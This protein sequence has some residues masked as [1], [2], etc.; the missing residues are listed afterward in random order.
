MPTNS[1]A[2]SIPSFAG[3][4]DE[5]APNFV[6]GEIEEIIIAPLELES[7]DPFPADWTDE[8]AWDE[9]LAPSVGDP[10]AFKIPVRGTIDEPDRPEIEA[11]KYRKAYPPPRY[12]LPANVDDLSDLAYDNMRELVNKRARLWYISGGYV[13]GHPQGIIAEVNSWQ[14]IE[15]GEDS[16]HRYHLHLSWRTKSP[17]E[18]IPSPFVPSEPTATE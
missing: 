13:F 11:S 5:C 14:T 18:R 2:D 6:F 9:I 1:C 17:P 12:N 8:D 4:F 16:M 15:E 7:G 3:A 10:I